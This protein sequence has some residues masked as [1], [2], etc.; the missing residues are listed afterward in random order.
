MQLV[1]SMRRLWRHS[2][3]R[4]LFAVR[5]V[6]QAADG[7]LQVGM[8]SYIL[9]SPTHAPDAWSIALALAVTLLPFSIVGPLVG[10]VLDRW[11]R[12]S[13]IYVTDAIRVFAAVMLAGMVAT[14]LRTTFSSIVFFSIVLLAMSLNRFLMA[15]LGASLAHTVDDDEYLLANSVIS[16]VGPLGVVIGAA[17]AAALRLGLDGILPSYQADAFIFIAAAIGFALSA[18]VATR[19]EPDALGPDVRTQVKVSEVLDGLREAAA[20]LYQRRPALLGIAT[21]GAHRVVYGLVMTGAILVHRNHL[22]T[23]EQLNTALVQ[24]GIWAGAT[25]AGYL[26]AAVVTPAGTNGFGVRTWIIV[27]TVVSALVQA[28]PGSWFAHPALVV[29]SFVLGICIQSLK[30]CVDTL[31]QAHI[32]DGMKGRVFTIFDMVFNAAMV[33]GA[34]IGAL[35][36]PT[37]GAS[38]PVF[39]GAAAAFGLIAVGF[40]TLS[41]PIGN[42]DFNKG[43]RRSRIPA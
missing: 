18:L 10:V 40:G 31:A 30:N 16:P 1:S 8:A 35:V 2:L 41:H 13:V 37:D 32:A 29:A 14:G 7:C 3:F 19:F 23:P 5:L 43:T 42:H 6:T 24:L 9:F 26:L 11:N 36:L 33:L 28:F 20:H 22:N 4:R 15:G 39:L 17:V 38:L 34:V 27:L 12:R 21:L 25:G